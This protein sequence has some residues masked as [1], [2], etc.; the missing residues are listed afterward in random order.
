MPQLKQIDELIATQE[1]LKDISTA[2]VEVSLLKIKKIRG[3]VEKNIQFGSDIATVYSLV[4]TAAAIKDISLKK[5]K[6]TVCFLFT[7]NERFYGNIHA[8]LIDFFIQSTAKFDADKVVIGKVGE[9]FIKAEKMPAEVL[10][11]DHDHPN[12]EQ[13]QQL[14]KIAVSY[15][16]V[17]FFYPQLKTL[18][19]QQPALIDLTEAGANQNLVQQ[20]QELFIFEPEIK[21]MLEFF[22]SSILTLLFDT[23]FLESELART[24]SRLISMD[25]AKSQAG[26]LISQ[27][28][29]LRSSIIRAVLDL[30]LLENVL[31]LRS[32]KNG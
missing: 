19:L 3:L 21:L 15:R 30:E 28:K 16:R 14:V 25:E 24:A 5:P 31:T 22:D 26:K 27:Q 13:T 9:S 7:S 4:K 18:L 10:I 12:L 11:F 32:I 1:S 29:R 2:L 20:A 17:M 6:N 23:V 8:Q